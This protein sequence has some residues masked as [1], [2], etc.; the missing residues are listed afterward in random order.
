M[1]DHRS[2]PDYSVGYHDALEGRAPA[3]DAVPY[4]A[5]WA[6]GRE[7]RDIFHKSGF[8][9]WGDGVFGINFTIGRES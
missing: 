1:K 5:G 3:H 7:A 8:T 2:H 9:D 4:T 6:A